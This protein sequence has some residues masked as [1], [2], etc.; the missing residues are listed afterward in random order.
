MLTGRQTA[1]FGDELPDGETGLRPASASFLPSTKPSRGVP[2]RSAILSLRLLW[3]G[4]QIRP[5]WISSQAIESNQERPRRQGSISA[6]VVT[7]LGSVKI[8][9]FQ[10]CEVNYQGAHF[11]AGSHLSR[12]RRR[13]LGIGM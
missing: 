10:S 13:S 8:Q 4:F 11:D 7:P 9:Q 6:P 3:I 12:M 1:A 2:A 5:R